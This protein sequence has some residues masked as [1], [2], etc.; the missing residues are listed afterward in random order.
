ML[1]W[2]D[3]PV[4]ATVEFDAEGRM[5]LNRGERLRDV[6]GSKAVLTPWVGRYGGYGEFGHFRV[7]AQIEVAWVLTAWSSSMPVSI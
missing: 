3:A 2:D 5:V 1:I 7:P 6:G 4:A